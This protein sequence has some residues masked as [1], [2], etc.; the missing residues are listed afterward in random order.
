MKRNGI[1]IGQW[2]LNPM[3]EECGV[4]KLRYT[5]VFSVDTDIFP[6]CNVILYSEGVT[7]EGDHLKFQKE[8]LMVRQSNGKYETFMK[9]VEEREVMMF[10]AKR[11]YGL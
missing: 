11:K 5:K 9:K 10:I 4:N 6:S 3:M 8:N 7:P 1:E 2:Y